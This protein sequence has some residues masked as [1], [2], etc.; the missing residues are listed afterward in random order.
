VCAFVQGDI[1]PTPSGG[2]AVVFTDVE[3]VRHKSPGERLAVRCFIKY[4]GNS[5]NG[6]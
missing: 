3:V 5:V 2:T 4:F 6:K 1:V